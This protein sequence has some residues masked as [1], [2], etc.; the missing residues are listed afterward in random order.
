MMFLEYFIWGAWYVTMGT[1]NVA[2]ECNGCSNRCR[3]QC[4]GDCNDPFPRFLL[5]ELADRFFSAQRIL[6][7]LHLVG[8]VL[9]Y[10]ATVVVKGCVLLDHFILFIALYAHHRFVQ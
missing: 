3:L 5:A 4:T 6:G 7:V 9:L 1:Y 8:A 2:F 10:M